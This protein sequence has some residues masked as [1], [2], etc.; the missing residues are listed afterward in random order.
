MAD[1][2]FCEFSLKGGGLK[3]WQK[4]LGLMLFE[5]SSFAGLGSMDNSFD[6]F[7]TCWRL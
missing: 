6:M 5:R 4:M 7:T 2:S 3:G 1:F